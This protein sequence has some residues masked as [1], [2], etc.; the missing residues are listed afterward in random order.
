MNN[1]IRFTLH[2]LHYTC[3]YYGGQQVQIKITDIENYGE[4]N[5]EKQI[6]EIQI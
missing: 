1:Q 5:R 3:K 6:Q 4:I 2:V